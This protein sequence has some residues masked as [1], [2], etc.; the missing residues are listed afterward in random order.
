MSNKFLAGASKKDITP[1]VGTLLYGYRPDLES[2]SVH[3][4]LSVTALAVANEDETALLLTVEVGDINTALCDDTR[5]KIASV[6]NV[7]PKH[8]LIS[9]T[10]TH[11]APNLS[12]VSGWGELNMEYYN[13]IFIPSAIT[14]CSEAINSLTP[15]EISVGVTESQVGINRRKQN[16]DGS[17]GL[18]QNPHA[19]YDPNMTVVSIRNSETKSGILTLYTMVATAHLPGLPKL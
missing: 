6:C 15:A 5:E 19:C 4:P 9:S 14:A 7:S 18:G 8:I 1:P 17:I 11:S 13:N 3:D 12:G 2:T 10:H 16:V